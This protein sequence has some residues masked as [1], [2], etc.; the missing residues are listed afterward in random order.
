MA[1]PNGCWGAARL[2]GVS[3]HDAN[4]E[5]G[6]VAVTKSGRSRS[7]SDLARL[8][9]VATQPIRQLDGCRYAIRRIHVS[10][11]VARGSGG[12]RLAAGGVRGR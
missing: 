9:C 8:R 6:E 10:G 12:R 5:S 7:G 11:I 2:S 4:R 3:C 1:D